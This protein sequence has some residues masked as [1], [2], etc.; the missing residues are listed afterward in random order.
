MYLDTHVTF[1]KRPYVGLD[2][3]DIYTISTY[4]DKGDSYGTI[5]GTTSVLAAPKNRKDSVLV[6]DPTTFT[7]GTSGTTRS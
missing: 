5:P 4:L 1:E 6:H 2:E 3:D 7:G